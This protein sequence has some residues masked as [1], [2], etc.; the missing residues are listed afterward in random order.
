[1]RTGEFLQ[2]RTESGAQ[3]GT[4]RD[5]MWIDVSN[6]LPVRTYQHISVVTAT[7]FGSS[8]YT[9]TG[10][11]TLRSLVAGRWSPTVDLQASG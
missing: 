9:Q 3:R 8:T 2:L 7:P 6:G 4:E 10:T 5:E 1:M 11:F